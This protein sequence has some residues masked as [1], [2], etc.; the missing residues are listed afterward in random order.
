[1]LSF[2]ATNT[3]CNNCCLITLKCVCY[4]VFISSEHGARRKCMDLNISYLQFYVQFIMLIASNMD[5]RT[6][7]H[8][9]CMFLWRWK[10][11][12]F[13]KWFN[14]Y[15]WTYVIILIVSKYIRLVISF[16]RFEAW[17]K[18]RCSCLAIIFKFSKCMP[19]FLFLTQMI[20]T[21]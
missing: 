19:S 1:M 3:L 15:V 9:I 13:K 8:V 12:M 20:V 7:L 11:I 4:F 16:R 18:L 14:L 21:E 17:S 6:F 2:K 10:T 5:Y